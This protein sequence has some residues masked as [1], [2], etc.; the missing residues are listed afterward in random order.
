MHKNKPAFK[1]GDQP[2][3][4]GYIAWHSWADAQ[5]RA[6]LRQSRCRRCELWWYPQEY[7]QADSICLKCVE[8]AGEADHER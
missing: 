1:P 3:S 6:G 7:H 4:S 2:P 8:L 5:H